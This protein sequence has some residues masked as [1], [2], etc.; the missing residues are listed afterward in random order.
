MVDPSVRIHEQERAGN[1]IDRL[2][3]PIRL[4]DDPE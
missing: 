1:R 4:G 3:V 2:F